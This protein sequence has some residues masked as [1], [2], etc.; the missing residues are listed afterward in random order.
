M[1]L[2]LGR[3]LHRNENGRIR[4]EIPRLEPK[5]V[6]GI[7]LV[8]YDPP[9]DSEAEDDNDDKNG[10][11]DASTTSA[12]ESTFP[13]SLSRR[14]RRFYFFAQ[15]NK[16]KKVEPPPNTGTST[17]VSNEDPRFEPVEFPFVVLERNRATCPICLT[18]FIEPK[19][20]GGANP[21]PPRDS[22]SALGHDPRLAA[23]STDSNGTPGVPLRMLACGHVFHVRPLPCLTL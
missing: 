7:P 10:A 20:K 18:D 12:P 16:L 3:P 21:A 2:S 23:D 6:D 13:T 11:Q 8:V 15:K 5:W 17:Q 4:P 9:L 1:L 14:V 19:R 22:I